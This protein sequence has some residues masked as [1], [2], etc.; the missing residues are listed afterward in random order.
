MNTIYSTIAYV[1]AKDIKINLGKEKTAMLL[2]KISENFQ[3]EIGRFI[4]F[5]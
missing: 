5:V 4:N 2:E 1:N 3:K